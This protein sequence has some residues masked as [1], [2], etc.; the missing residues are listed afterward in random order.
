[1]IY[2]D[3]LIAPEGTIVRGFARP[4]L[5]RASRRLRDEALPLF[6]KHNH[7][8]VTARWSRGDL[9]LAG[10][11][12]TLPGVEMGAWRR[13]LDMWNVFNDRGA[14]VLQYVER[15]TVIYQ[16]STTNGRP[17]GSRKLEDR[18]MGFRLSRTPI[19]E[20]VYDVQYE[21][22]DKDEE[23]HA[24]ALNR[25]E[26]DWPSRE[27]TERLLFEKMKQHGKSE[28]EK[29]GVL[30]ESLSLGPPKDG[31]S[32]PYKRHK[33]DFS[34]LLTPDL[35]RCCAPVGN[36][37]ARKAGQYAVALCEGLP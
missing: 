26:F 23:R 18:R 36:L 6:Y 31:R 11:Q 4:P 17:F 35:C 7:F 10:K 16:F 32:P 14:D 29:K 28:V 24:V 34:S 25:G 19:E 33:E 5:L 22:D 8:E 2:R 30:G 1:M 9:L 37:A 12:R 3:V 21:G 15:V 27:E 13:F 20:A